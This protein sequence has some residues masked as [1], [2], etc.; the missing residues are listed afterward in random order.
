MKTG[1]LVCGYGG[2]DSLD[3]VGP[4]MKN[5]MGVEP[6]PQLLERVTRRYLAIG[7]QSPLTDIARGIAAALEA[8]LV[9]QGTPMPVAVGMAYWRPFIADSLSMLKEGGCDRVVA[10][11]LS[12]FE[13]KIAHG[14][15]REAILAATDLIGDIEVVEAPLVSTLPEFA[16]FF[17]DATKTDLEETECGLNAVLAFTA[18]SLPESDLTADDQYVDGLETTA[19]AVAAQ[20][21]LPAGARDT[22]IL[23]GL[24]TFGSVEGKRPWC[25]I[26]QSKGN[27]PGAWLGPELSDLFDAALAADEPPAIVAIPIG[28]MTDHMETLYDLDIEAA[29]FAWDNELQFIRVQVPNDNEH[30]VAAI[31][32]MVSEIA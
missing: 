4:F 28:F 25:L 15:Y 27:R 23:P 32:G 9:K 13:S 8:A 14:K 18:H 30:L 24:R 29:G 7:G 17:S 31:A 10:V 20:M 6:S 16:Q 26:Y 3:A 19:N 12:P 1:V 21:G 2:P 5:L 11:T 22:E